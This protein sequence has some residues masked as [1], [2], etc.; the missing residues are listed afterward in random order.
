LHERN[1]NWEYPKSKKNNSKNEMARESKIGPT[2]SLIYIF[3]VL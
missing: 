1:G 3:L 2:D